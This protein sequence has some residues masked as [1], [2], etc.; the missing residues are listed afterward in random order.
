MHPIENNSLLLFLGC[1]IPIILF[2]LR[3]SSDICMYRSSKIFNGN[4]PKGN[5]RTLSKGKRGIVSGI[6]FGFISKVFL[7]CL[8]LII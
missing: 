8:P 3:L 7:N 1:I 4:L 6:L 2:D 5:K